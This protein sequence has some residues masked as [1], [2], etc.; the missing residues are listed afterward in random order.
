MDVGR[1]GLGAEPLADVDIA[2]LLRRTVRAR[3]A[4]A[5]ADCGMSG[6]ELARLSGVSEACLSRILTGKRLPNP[7]ALVRLCVALNV[8][9]DWLLGLR[10]VP[11]AGARP[12]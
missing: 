8:S 12:P 2:P 4:R 1:D 9:A 6:R 7:D 3:L 5:L 10:A 11:R